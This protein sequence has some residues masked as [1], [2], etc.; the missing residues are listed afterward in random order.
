MD[1]TLW[2]AI[3]G[4][5]VAYISL[6]ISK[7]QKI[8]D[9]RQALIDSLRLESSTCVS[10]LI[11][12]HSYLL[13]KSEGNEIGINDVLPDIAE[14]NIA[15][16][17]LHMRLNPKNK[18][19]KDLMLAI[20]EIEN[21][22]NSTEGVL[23]ELK[24]L[25]DKIR[26]LSKIILKNEWDRARDGETWFRASKIIAGTVVILGLLYAAFLAAN[27]SFYEPISIAIS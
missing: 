19:S 13:M 20:E 7:E 18:D 16:N 27:I 6:V 9:F 21:Y 25:I 8:S 26:P 5:G 1:S 12:L 14:L 11:K 15:L 23:E 4:G 24:P 2:A 22:F 17:S 10:L 3:I